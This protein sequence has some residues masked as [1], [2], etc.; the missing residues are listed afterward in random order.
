MKYFI[1][2]TK[3]KGISVFAKNVILKNEFIGEYYR[4]FPN[5]KFKKN[6]FG[7]YD[8]DLGRYCNQWKRVKFFSGGSFNI[9]YTT[10]DGAKFYSDQLKLI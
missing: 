1:A 3:T 2:Q 10:Y 7:S 9:Y 6:I 4:H 8:R 5:E